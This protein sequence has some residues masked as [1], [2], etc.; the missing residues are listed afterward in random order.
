[1]GVSVQ[2]VPVK[3]GVSIQGDLCPERCLS[4]GLCPERCLSGGV[5][6]QGVSVWGV[7][8]QGG[9][10]ARVRTVTYGRYASY[11]NAFLLF[12]FALCENFS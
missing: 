4:G 11:C 2:G 3:R 8:V 5:S 6:V 10:S 12:L 7:S 9:V 1:M